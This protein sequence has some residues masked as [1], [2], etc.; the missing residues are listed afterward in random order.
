MRALKALLGP[1]VDAQNQAGLEGRKKGKVM[2]VCQ[3]NGRVPGS[4]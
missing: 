4:D 1:I 3:D 2:H